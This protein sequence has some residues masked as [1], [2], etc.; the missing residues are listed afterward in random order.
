MVKVKHLLHLIVMIQIEKLPKAYI[1][2]EI[3]AKLQF[4]LLIRKVYKLRWMENIK[5]SS[6]WKG[7][8]SSILGVP[9]KPISIM[10]MN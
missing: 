7:I 3:L 6:H 8:L 9:L 1:L 2:I 4:F 10:K 5:M